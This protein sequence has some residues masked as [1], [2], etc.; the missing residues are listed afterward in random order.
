M[1]VRVSLSDAYTEWDSGYALRSLIRNGYGDQI[2][3][4]AEQMERACQP[5]SHE[6]LTKRLTALGMTMAANRPAAEATVW[7]HETTR[8][9]RDLPQD[10]VYH[11]IDECQ[12]KQ[13]FLPTVAEIREIADPLRD[14]RRKHASKLDA[15]A[16]LLEGGFTVTP[17]AEPEHGGKRC[18]GEEAERILAEEGLLSAVRGNEAPKVE[19]GPLRKPTR[20]DYL[21]MGVDPAVLDSLMAGQQAA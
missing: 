15:M 3:P 10:I 18:T 8:L 6:A 11:A 16:R 9:L 20:Q 4:L 21:E 14:E 17:P 13:R 1:Q 5:V 2:R 7:L 12:R 19:R